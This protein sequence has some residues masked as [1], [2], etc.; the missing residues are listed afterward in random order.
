MSGIAGFYT[1]EK[2]IIT[3]NDLQKLKSCLTHRGKDGGDIFYYENCGLIHQRL[4]TIDLSAGAKQPMTSHSQRYVGVLDGVIY[5]YK[6]IATDLDIELDTKSDIEVI[7][8]AFAKWGVSFVNKLNGMFAIAI[9]DKKENLLYLFRDRFGAKALYYFLNDDSVIFASEIQALLSVDVVNNSK[10]L[11]PLSIQQFLHLGYIPEPKTIYQ[12][13]QKFPNASFAIVS[14]SSIKIEPYWTIESVISNAVVSDFQVAKEKI[15]ILME[16]S[17]KMRIDTCDVNLGILLS[18]GTDSTLITAIA[19]KYKRSDKLNTFAIGLKDTNN[20]V[21]SSAREISNYYGTNHQ[22][23]Q[24]EKNDFV[25]IFE[26][27]FSY[28]DEPFFDYLIFQTLILN[29]KVKNAGISSTL[30]GY[31]GNELFYGHKSYNMAQSLSHFSNLPFFMKGIS[32]ILKISKKNNLKNLS[33][34]YNLGSD[35][36][37][38][39]R[40]HIFSQA[41]NLFSITELQNLLVNEINKYEMIFYSE[42]DNFRRTLSPEEEQALFDF[43]YYFKD[44]LLAMVDKTSMKY[45]LEIRMPLLDNNI[46]EYSLN[47]DRNFKINRNNNKFILKQV[48]NEYIPENILPKMQK[49]VSIPLQTWLQTDKYFSDL[50]NRYLNKEIINRFKVVKF[51]EVNK[52]VTNYKNGHSYLYNR[53]WLLILLHKFLSEK[54][55]N[56]IDLY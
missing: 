4:S 24:M 29:E 26:N 36:K 53:I 8:E 5:N 28:F 14:H 18:G 16:K 43:R 45:A 41:N 3:E 50:L 12:N 37:G 34:M 46:V 40:S 20:H 31:G 38:I 47:I 11:N 49:S 17:I 25:N 55:I 27:Y 13:I 9:F 35:K 54:N 10:K 1:K 22:E 56:T 48:L 39:L 33:Q 2:N 52:I 6:E 44:D 23:F 15:Q 51:D 19:N 21:L 32:S 30:A 7:I 42:F